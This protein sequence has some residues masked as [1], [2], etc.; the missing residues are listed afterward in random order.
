MLRRS[1]ASPYPVMAAKYRLVTL[2]KNRDEGGGA[3]RPLRARS[4][5]A[6]PPL[7]LPPSGLLV[8]VDGWEGVCGGEG[9]CAYV[10]VCGRGEGRRVYVYVCRPQFVGL[11]ASVFFLSFHFFLSLSCFLLLLFSSFF[12]SPF[13]PFLPSFVFH[14]FF[15]LPFHPFLESPSHSPTSSL[16]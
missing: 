1:V 15:P 16:L 10:C 5:V 4:T 8:W 12:Y 6:M 2:R 3:P 9:W 7:L 13:Q 14:L 11:Y